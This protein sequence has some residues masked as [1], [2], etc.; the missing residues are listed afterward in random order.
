MKGQIKLKLEQKQ[1]QRLL[2]IQLKLGKMLELNDREVEDLIVATVDENPAL[3]YKYDEDGT[4]KT[5]S[6]KNTDFSKDSSSKYKA[7][8]REPDDGDFWAISGTSTHETLLENIVRQLRD[9]HLNEDE[10]ELGEYMAAALDSNGYFTRTLA[11][12]ADDILIQT[13]KDPKPEVLRKVWEAIR[14][15]DPAGIGAI[16]LKDCLLLQLE[17]KNQSD[18]N[19]INA[20]KIIE[21]AYDEF[22]KQKNNSIAEK[23]GLSENDI[24]N[25]LSLIA[26]LNP[27]PGKE[28]FTSDSESKEMHVVPD[29]SVLPDPYNDDRLTISFLTE[30]PELAIEESFVG[31]GSNDTM[32]SDETRRRNREAALFM[33]ERIEEAENFLNLLKIRNETLYRITKAI[34]ERQKQYFLSGDKLDLKPMVLRDISGDT[35]YDLSVLSRATSNRYL[36]T[37]E[38]IVPFKSLFNEKKEDGSDTGTTA[39]KI[40]SLIKDIVSSENRTAPYSDDEIVGLLTDKG[41]NIARRTVA[42]YRE[43]LGIDSARKRKVTS[44]S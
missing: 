40:M 37:V 35:G 9:M 22:L 32:V 41:V 25:A 2:P 19:V 5:E 4:D 29:I 10:I 42:K 20:G 43:T 44:K 8:N 18:P 14:S 31:K 33:K 30:L 3:T 16:D 27:K 15:A 21:T 39:L 17:R 24:D 38:G 23:T 7:F 34:V 12:I 28:F 1:Q 26:R 11:G 6:V 36:L 13:G